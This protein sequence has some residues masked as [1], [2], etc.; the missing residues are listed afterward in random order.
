MSAQEAGA[1]A[2]CSSG[3]SKRNASPLAAT[4]TFS[5]FG[6]APRV[7]GALAGQTGAYRS[8]APHEPPQAPRARAGQGRARRRVGAAAVQRLPQQQRGPGR[9]ALQLDQPPALRARRA[10]EMRVRADGM[11]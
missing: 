6:C 3:T 7:P 8:M 2:G 1:S 5:M 10:P 11:A 4:A 9:Q